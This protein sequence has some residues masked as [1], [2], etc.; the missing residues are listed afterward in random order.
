MKRRSASDFASE[1][2]GIRW[3]THSRIVQVNGHLLN[4]SASLD[5]PFIDFSSHLRLLSSAA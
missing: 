3:K 4:V 2:S 5:G 1:N